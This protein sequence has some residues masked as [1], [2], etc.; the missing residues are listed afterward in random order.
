[1]ISNFPP[2]FSILKEETEMKKKSYSHVFTLFF[3]KNDAK[4]PTRNPTNILFSLKNLLILSSLPCIT[5]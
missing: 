2:K 1:M 3:D 5:A 4:K